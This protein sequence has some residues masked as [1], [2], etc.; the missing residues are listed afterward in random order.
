[1]CVSLSVYLC[2]WESICLCEC[3]SVYVCVCT[4][5]FRQHVTKLLPTR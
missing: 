1:M 5:A 4:D 2:A 3:L